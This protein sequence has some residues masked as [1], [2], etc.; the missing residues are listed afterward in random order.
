[1]KIA[2]ITEYY[3]SRNYGG[4]LQA[5]ALYR[6]ASSLIEGAE[7][8]QISYDKGSGS[9]SLKRM[10]ALRFLKKATRYCIHRAIKPFKKVLSRKK[11]RLIRPLLQ[12]RYRC[13]DAFNREKIPHSKVY[14][15]A[16]IADAAAEYDVFITGSDQVWNPSFWNPAYRLEFVPSGKPKLSYAASISRDHVSEEEAEIFRKSLADYTAISVREERAVDLLSP[17][18]PCEVRWVLDPTL[19]LTRDDWDAI[20]DARRVPEKYIFCYF[21]GDDL[22]ARQLARE[23]AEKHGLLLATIPFLNG[24]YRKCDVEFGDIRLSD[25]SPSGFIS[26]IKYAEFVFTDSFHATVFSGIY[27]RQFFV[28]DRSVS[29]HSMGSRLDSL[30]SLYEAQERFG[31]CEE[32]RCLAYIEALPPIDGARRLEGLEVMKKTSLDFLRENLKKV[33]EK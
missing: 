18:A 23:Y 31:N 13:L 16:T 10:G 21:L 27:K 14:N 1:M 19:L 5:Y 29:G 28:F 11:E 12:E 26:L 6:A 24:A 15:T 2:I 8:E 17:L 4:N 33:E 30:L 20:C 25:V 32:R 9:R 22:Q 3:K 7:V